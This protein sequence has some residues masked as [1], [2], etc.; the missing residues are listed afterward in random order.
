M[1]R[2]MRKMVASAAALALTLT[3]CAGPPEK[4]ENRVPGDYSY[5]K[6]YIA[7]LIDKEME[8]EEVIGLSIA[9][10]DDQQ[11][12]WAQ[13]F[14]FADAA[15]KAAAT[16]ETIYRAGSISKLFTATATMQLAEQGRLDIDQPIQSSLPEFSIQSRFANGGPITPRTLMT[17]HSGL[18]SDLAQG[19]W[20]NH[21]EPFG[22]VVPML[23][24]EYVATAANTVRSYS[25]LG[26]TV[27]GHALERVAG[28]PYAE[29]LD[30]SLLSPLGMTH[31]SFSQAPANSPLMSKGYREGKEVAEAPLRDLP[32]GGLNTTVLDLSRFMAMVFANGRAG[33]RQLIR[34]ETLAEMLRPQNSTVPLDLDRRIGLAWF[35]DDSDI[36]NA[37]PVAEHGG[38][39]QAHRSQL[40]L[41]PEHKL[42]VV[43]LANSETAGGRLVRKVA[44]ETLKLALEAKAGIKQPEQP[45]KTAGARGQ[46]S[47]DVLQAYEGDYATDFGVVHITPKSG[48]LEAKIAGEEGTFQL[49]PRPDG[50]L[51]VRRK[52]FGLIPL[53]LGELDQVGFS[54]ATVAGHEIVK[55]SRKGRETLAG[56]R[57]QPVP[58]P[59]AWQQ[60]LGAYEVVNGG[61]DLLKVVGARLY[62]Q[63][64]LLLLEGEISMGPHTPVA[65]QTLVIAPQSDREAVICGLGRGKGETIRVVEV[66]GAEGLQYSGYIFRRK[67]NHRAELSP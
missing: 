22:Q 63:Q 52:L 16:P 45:A 67:H 64:G 55:A 32:A 4:A 40:T 36:G 14:G 35:L 43:V 27:L 44:T 31:S 3:S 57:I 65:K 20:T 7:W 6:A 58:M 25:N 17:H 11:V 23:R 60:R 42:G 5:T 1:Q 26:V 53:S 47:R 37:G 24:D 41:L 46:L 29:L 21:P 56:E 54:L 50:L 30:D 62:Q 10:V 19:M 13:G 18:P 66:D 9:L 48:T 49:V 39:T 61:E 8:K 59:Q 38:A 15:N 33:D 28:Q 34:P 51:G 2:K 12:V